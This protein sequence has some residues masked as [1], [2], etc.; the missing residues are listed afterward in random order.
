MFGRDGLCFLKF[1]RWQTLGQKREDGMGHPL[2]IDAGIRMHV[3]MY[4]FQ[5]DLGCA[6]ISAATRF[7]GSTRG[8]RYFQFNLLVR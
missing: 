6:R 4:P 5:K 7:S 2:G 3:V 8:G 1:G